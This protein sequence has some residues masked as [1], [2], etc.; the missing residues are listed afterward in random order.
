[1]SIDVLQSKMRKLKNPSMLRLDV[2]FDAL[3]P[4]LQ[5]Q[6]QEKGDGHFQFERELLEALKD[7]VPAVCF[8][9][10]SY[11][12]Y[13][14]KRL[15]QLHKNL[16]FAKKLGYY[17]LLQH[18]GAITAQDAQKA[19]AL[20]FSENSLWKFDG[21]M[22]TGLIGTDGIEPFVDAAAETDRDVF[23]TIRTGNKSAGVVQDLMTG[24]RLSYMATA[25]IV[26]RL[27][28]PFRGK[29]GYSRVGGVGPATSAEALK[30]LRSKYNDMFLI[31]QGYD[32]PS[33]NAKLCAPGFD[34]L[35]YGAI[36]L[37][38]GAIAAAWTEED[39]SDGSDFCQ[40]AVAAA[41]RMKKNITRYVT[42][43]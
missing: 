23:V 34:K 11:A 5:K 24:G 39:N 35:G 1:M 8:D 14:S 20:L 32:N 37:S 30:N 17:V 10:D 6:E 3:P 22:I 28:K 26:S 42:I 15:E 33:A 41:E 16:S 4:E 31:L 43:L 29:F 36:V 21:L 25:D 9:F 18:T 40:L 12:L 7:T 27:G 38:E 19:A 13:G 2:S